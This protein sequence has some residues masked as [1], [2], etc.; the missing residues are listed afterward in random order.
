[1]AGTERNATWHL[2]VHHAEVC[3]R[4]VRRTLDVEE[5]LPFVPA[6]GPPGWM[7][8]LLD[9]GMMV[10]ARTSVA[11]H[12]MAI[13][14]EIA[15]AVH[16]KG[17]HCIPGSSL[18]DVYTSPVCG[19]VTGSFAANFLFFGRDLQDELAGIAGRLG[20]EAC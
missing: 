14:V 10:S 17:L 12:S 20:I 16:T 13:A 1:L 9:A 15:M 5:I 2:E 4:T 18:E 8:A 11:R 7:V 19:F 3:K 6:L